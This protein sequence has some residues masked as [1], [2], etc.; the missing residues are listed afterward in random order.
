MQ[1]ALN[2]LKHSK[3][4]VDALTEERAALVAQQSHWSDLK[5]TAEHVECLR[6]L[7]ENQAKQEAQEAQRLRDR[8]NVLEGELSALQKLHSDQENKLGNMQR[9]AMSHKQSVANAQQRASEFEKRLK[10]REQEL[11]NHTYKLEQSE[12]SRKE[13]TEELETLKTQLQEYEGNLRAGQVG[14]FR[15]DTNSSNNTS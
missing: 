15:S 2:E 5:R 8:T 9:A 12:A 6:E 11:Q 10:E 1:V 13:T 7:L 4:S 14:T 3:A